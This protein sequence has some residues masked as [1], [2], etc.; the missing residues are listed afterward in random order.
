MLPTDKKYRRE[1]VTPAPWVDKLQENVFR[2][3]D[4]ELLELNGRRIQALSETGRAPKRDRELRL[5]PGTVLTREY[6]G[7]EHHVAVAALG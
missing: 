3:V 2:K 1:L 5:L 7:I 4:A 6:R